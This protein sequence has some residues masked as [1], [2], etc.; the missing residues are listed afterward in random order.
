[1][2]YWKQPPSRL[3]PC[4]PVVKAGGEA[5]A[6]PVVGEAREIAA[7]VEGGAAGVAAAAVAGGGA[8]PRPQPPPLAFRRGGSSGR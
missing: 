6:V 4:S 7:I 1:M 5:A 8:G 2:Y 3:Q